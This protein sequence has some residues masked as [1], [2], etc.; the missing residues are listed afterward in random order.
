MT[1]DQFMTREVETLTEEGTLREAIV[2]FQKHRIRHL[3]IVRGRSIVGIVTD[4]DLKRAS[5]SLLS[6]VSQPEFDRVLNE[7]R[8]AQVMTR[9]PFTVTPSTRLKDAV[10]ILLDNKYSCLPVV[11]GDKLV[12]IITE[13]DLLRAFHGMLED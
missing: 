7:T 4:R 1:V 9:N 12:G 13:T 2:L 3:P 8:L 6:G 10:K 11:E 5:P